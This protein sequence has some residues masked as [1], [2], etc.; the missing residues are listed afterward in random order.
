MKAITPLYVEEIN[1]LEGLEDIER[2]IP[3]FEINV[4]ETTSE[5]GP[6]S[7]LK[8]DEYEPDPES[9]LVLS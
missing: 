4:L 5:Y 8:E 9:M 7:A 2:I 1:M 6:M 3:L